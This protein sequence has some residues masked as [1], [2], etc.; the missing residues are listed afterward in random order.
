MNDVVPA[1]IDFPPLDP[2]DDKFALAVVEYNG[3]LGA[4]Y[5][6]VFG[7]DQYSMAKAR[8]I[9]TR[10]EIAHR[11]AYLARVVDEQ[12]LISLGSHLVKLA[13]I[14]DSALHTNQHAVALKAE[15]YRGEVA[16]FYKQRS[17]SLE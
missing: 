12:T 2:E 13:E 5:E 11:I 3:N 15:R 10:P 7:R 8:E 1:K 9:I 17:E 14:R 16:G 4:A 6:A